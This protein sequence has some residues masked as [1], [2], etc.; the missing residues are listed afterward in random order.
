MC[1]EFEF[2][3]IEFKLFWVGGKWVVGVILED[4][5]VLN[6]FFMWGNDEFFLFGSFIE[7]VKFYWD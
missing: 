3:C 4:D 5:F 1:G 6:N 7:I 2:E